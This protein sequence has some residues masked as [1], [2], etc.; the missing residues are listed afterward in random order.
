MVVNTDDLPW[1]IES[2]KNHQKETNKIQ[3]TSGFPAFCDA[4]KTALKP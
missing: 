3:A 4:A 2:K 1:Y